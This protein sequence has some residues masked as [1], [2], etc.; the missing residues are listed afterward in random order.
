MPPKQ[1]V[2]KAIAVRRVKKQVKRL[3]KRK[4]MKTLQRVAMR[5]R[6]AISSAAAEKQLNTLV[7]LEK[8]EMKNASSPYRAPVDQRR[9]RIERSAAPYHPTF[10]PGERSTYFYMGA[11]V[12]RTG[13]TDAQSVGGSALAANNEWTV[14]R[15]IKTGTTTYRYNAGLLFYPNMTPTN[16]AT[17]PA[18]ESAFA[19]SISSGANTADYNPIFDD[20]KYWDQIA[21]RSIEVDYSPSVPYTAT[22]NLCLSAV[23]DVI[24]A[25][26][27]TSPTAPTYDQAC[28]IGLSARCKI[29]DRLHFNILKPSPAMLARP[30]PEVIRNSTGIDYGEPIWVLHGAVDTVNALDVVD[31]LG[32]LM[33][34]VVIDKYSFHWVPQI[35]GS[36]LDIRDTFQSQVVNSFKRLGISLEDDSDFE[37]GILEGKEKKEVVESKERKEDVKDRPKVAEDYFKQKFVKVRPATPRTILSASTSSLTT[38][39][40]PNL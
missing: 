24:E 25:L 15:H 1:R 36:A 30:A 6:T 38:A 11:E 37:I 14:L 34:T 35:Y 12:A 28:S 33:I 3:A 16:T 31:K 32:T 26:Y 23:N 17:R 27:S 39:S 9:Y 40:A 21:V 20:L 8:K 4:V 29:S 19:T 5:P 13:S 10:G 18:Y 7:K 2:R 22:G